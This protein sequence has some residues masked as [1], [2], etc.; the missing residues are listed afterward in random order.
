MVDSAGVATQGDP[1]AVGGDSGMTGVSVRTALWF[2]VGDAR[3]FELRGWG[4]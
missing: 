1:G 3:R 4:G 2:F